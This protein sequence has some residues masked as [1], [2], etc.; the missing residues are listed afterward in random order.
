[1]KE[2]I[3]LLTMEH[4]SKGFTDRILFDDVSLGINENDR[5]GV[6]GINGTGKSTLLKM[7]AGLISPDSGTITKGKSLKIAYLPQSPVFDPTMTILENVIHGQEAE[8]EYHNLAGEARAMLTSLGITNPDG[9]ADKL[10]G[11][12]KKRAALVRTLLA[13]SGL[14]VL[15]EPTNHLDSA[16]TE[17]LEN[18]LNRYR[19]AFLMVTHDRYFLDRVTNRIVEIDKGHLYSYTANYSRFLELKAEREEMAL[20]TER[21]AKSLYRM[22]LEWMQRGARARSTKQKAHIGRFEALRDREKIEVDGQVEINSVS[23]RLGKK[24]IILDHISKGFHGQTLIFDF[25]YILLSTD[26]IGIIGPNGCGKSTLLKLITGVYPPDSGTVECGTTV[27]IGYFSQE[28]EAMDETMRV[29]DYIRD[30]AE[31]IR[32]ADGMIT[33]SQIC[34]KFLFTGAMQYSVIAKLSG[35]EKRRLYLLKVLM[36][37]PNILVLDEPTND[38]DIQTLTILEDYLKTFP[39]I[40]LAVSHDRYFLDKIAARIFAFEGNGIIRQ[41]E[42]NYS[43]YKQA[44]ELSLENSDQGSQ[45]SKRTQ[46]ENKQNNTKTEWKTPSTTLRFTYK[47]QKEYKTIDS[48]IAVLEEKL[49]SVEKE[50]EENAANYSRLFELTSKKEEIQTALDEK[51]E[52]WVYL[53][54]LAEKI[55][56]QKKEKL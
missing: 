23:S 39:G 3:N 48:E 19:G 2:P 41:Y 11:G 47:E 8:S 38:L 17:W 6:I 37:A 14:L 30:T 10:S 25:S 7:I 24:T 5:I 35:G 27:K 31:Y 52:R 45:K 4:I 9:Q 43:D 42:G 29:I 1:M 53:N 34:E 55:D 50:I 16:M 51:M 44:Y 49:S 20:A 46:N 28:N 36:E 12:Q 56:A 33:A 15:D 26:R 40:I 13:P 18:Y 54:D 21:K 22:E 32:T